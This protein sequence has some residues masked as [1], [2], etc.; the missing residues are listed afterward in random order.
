MNYRLRKTIFKI[1]ILAG[2]L[3][4]ISKFLALGDVNEP[5]RNWQTNNTEDFLVCFEKPL[6]IKERA[7][8]TTKLQA[9][10]EKVFSP[11]QNRHFLVIR[12]KLKHSTIKQRISSLKLKV[13]FVE[14]VVER[15]LSYLPNDSYFFSQWNLRDVDAPSAWDIEDGDN[16]NPVI[17]IID[18]GA[19][20]DHEELKGRLWVNFDETAGDGIDNDRN[21]YVDDVYGLNVTGV[22]QTRKNAHVY[23][24]TSF[25]MKVAQIFYSKGERI[26]KLVFSLA[27]VGSPTKPVI[28]EVFEGTPDNGSKVASTSIPS[29]AIYPYEKDISVSFG[30]PLQLGKDK[31]YSFVLSTAETDDYNYYLVFNAD[32]TN[33]EKDFFIRGEERIFYGVIQ[34]WI[35]ANADLYFKILPNN[36]PYDDE[37]HGTVVSSIA[38]AETNNNLLIAGAAPRAKLMI[39]KVSSSD[40]IRS[41]DLVEGI[42]YAAKNGADVLNMSLSGPTYSQAEM[43]A[44]NFAISHGCLPV[45]AAGNDG[46]TGLF[47]PAAY[48]GV[49]GISSYGPNRVISSFSN[50]GS[51]VDLSAP[52]EDVP[53]ITPSYQQNLPSLAL[54]SGTSMSTPHV[55]AAAALTFSLQPELIGRTVEKLLIATAVDLGTVGLDDEYGYG[56]VNFYRALSFA[57]TPTIERFSG[58]DRYQT[59][60]LISSRFFTESTYAVLVTGENFP[61]SLTA[62]PLAAA[63]EAPLLLTRRNFLPTNVADE[64]K[65]LKAKKVFVVGGTGA[66]SEEVENFL[67]YNLGLATERLSGMDRYETSVKVA[68][69]LKELTGKPSQ[70]FVATGENFPDAL[71]AVPFAASLKAPLL[72]V[73]KVQIPLS[74]LNWIAAETMQEKFTKIFIIG[75]TGVISADLENFLKSNAE[76]VVRLGGQDRY[77]TNYKIVSYLIQNSNFRKNEFLICTGEN[78]PDA[79]SSGPV[80]ARNLNV[81]I[82]VKPSYFL[83]SSTVSALNLLG[84]VEK[85]YI[86]GGLGSLPKAAAS[87]V[88][89]EV[90]F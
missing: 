70:I 18:T 1:F 38:A 39:V 48:K 76:I 90:K 69:K 19:D 13:K 45:A 9:S 37:G 88:Y 79:L 71:S 25:G 16:N 29:S 86:A 74:V 43:D 31:T 82:L 46:T 36:L 60:V 56:A 58:V 89:E 53:A 51:F 11:T 42:Y 84:P 5:R 59:A 73:K 7:Q 32:Y 40:S 44:L 8:L 10:I 61:D 78:F 15:R 33:S 54:A 34:R 50:W 68:E 41:S 28:V 20:L 30:K 63:L 57:S 65:R 23:L 21:G 83:K 26:N 24:G 17:A 6:R 4:A 87:R 72:L 35:P 64:L 22:S 55:S 77:E 85:I 81:V 47:Y 67:S 14:P 12:S 49:M 2:F 66:V 52:G 62:G 75:G 27:K 80:A 3:F